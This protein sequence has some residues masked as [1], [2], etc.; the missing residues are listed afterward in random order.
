MTR[1]LTTSAPELDGAGS[2]CPLGNVGVTTLGLM[3][4]PVAPNPE[5]RLA[6]PP[7]TRVVPLAAPAEAETVGGTV[8]TTVFEVG[9]TVG[10]VAAELCS[11][12]AGEVLD[13]ALGVSEV[14]APV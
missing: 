12:V 10:S 8:A 14:V 13:V 5:L 6:E 9:S 11:V 1:G 4:T 2:K 7:T 3:L